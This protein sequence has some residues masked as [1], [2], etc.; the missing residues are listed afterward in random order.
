MRKTICPVCNANIKVESL[1]L[2]RQFH[3]PECD[4]LLEVVEENPLKLEEVFEE[5]EGKKD[6]EDDD[7][8]DDEEGDLYEQSLN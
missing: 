1:Y 2:F 7:E 6:D 8:D 5:G 4:V 3:C